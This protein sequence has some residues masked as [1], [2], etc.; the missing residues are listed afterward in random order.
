M[1]EKEGRVNLCINNELPLFAERVRLYMDSLDD[2]N[3]AGCE[4]QEH[5]Y[6]TAFVLYCHFSY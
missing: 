3:A 4:N 5:S 2:D 6:G 1:G